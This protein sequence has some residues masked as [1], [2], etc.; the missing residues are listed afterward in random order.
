MAPSWRLLLDL[1]GR[2]GWQNMAT[3][4]GP[5]RPSRPG[6]TLAPALPLVPALS[7]VRPTRAGPAQVRPATD[8]GPAP[9]RGAAADR[10]PGRV[11]RRGADLRRGGTG[12]A[13]RRS[14]RGLRRDPPDAAGRAALP[15]RVGRSR[16]P[17]RRH[18][19]GRGSLL[20]LA[21]RRRD[22][23]RRAEAGRQRP[24]QRRSRAAP[25]WLPAAR[26]PSDP[27][28]RMS[29]SAL[30][31]RISRWRWPTSPAARR[32]PARWRRPWRAPHRRAGAAPGSAK[33]PTARS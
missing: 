3:G 23:G 22:H 30:R 14:A 19:G 27:P 16:A 5:A 21:R 4:P 10:R 9:R 1:E 2:P 29:P 28:C 33:R 31:H 32:I 13:F 11:A 26:R 8:R 25:A 15:G 24:A 7:L 18:R 17:A 20:R 12:R 6:R